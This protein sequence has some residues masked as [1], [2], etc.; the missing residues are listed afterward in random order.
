LYHRAE[1][2]VQNLIPS[3]FTGMKLRRNICFFVF[4]PGF[5]LAKN[6]SSQFGFS[7]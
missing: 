5:S 3:F 4:A 7:L 2:T 1:A 6:T